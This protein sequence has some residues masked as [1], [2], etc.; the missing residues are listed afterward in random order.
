MTLVVDSSSPKTQTLPLP[1]KRVLTLVDDGSF[2]P[3]NLQALPPP[4]PPC[5]PAS[6]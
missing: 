2:V 5:R 6:A 3:L 1:C 4:T